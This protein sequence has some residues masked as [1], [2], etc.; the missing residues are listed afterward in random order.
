MSVRFCEDLKFIRF[1]NHKSDN[2]CERVYDVGNAVHHG[3]LT[4]AVSVVRED[5]AQRGIRAVALLGCDDFII[6]N[7]TCLR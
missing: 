3:I 5:F 2:D 6:V 4:N 7:P 1:V